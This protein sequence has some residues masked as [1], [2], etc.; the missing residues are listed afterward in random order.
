[1]IRRDN[2]GDLVCT[3]PMLSLLR[4]ARLDAYIAALANDYNAPVLA[5]NPDLDEVFVYAKAKHRDRF[6]GRVAAYWARA[7][8]LIRLRRRLRFDY[9]ILASSGYEQYALR[10]AR[11]ASIRVTVGYAPDRLG[12]RRA[13]GPRR[14]AAGG[15]RA[16]SAVGLPA[17]G[18]AGNSSEAGPHDGRP[19]DP[20]EQRAA[21]A[22][23][24][25]R[26][27]EA[28]LLIGVRLSA[29]EPARAWPVERFAE[30]I[31]RLDIPGAAFL[32]LWSPGG[33]A[34]AYH[35]GDDETAVALLSR[36]PSERVC[37]ADNHAVA[38]DRRGIAVSDGGGERRRCAPHRGCTRR[39]ERGVV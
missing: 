17:V 1:M 35:P 37:D 4:R 27:G 6:G 26:L 13:A 18:A 36:V 7:G 39:A 8:L 16:S 19:P 30:L 34:N 21:R 11:L 38:V 29:R 28:R 5:G 14:G 33:R 10:T 31:S 9:V 23:I 32:V 12:R 22:R 25:E 3:T 15:A 20:A 24:A 2:I